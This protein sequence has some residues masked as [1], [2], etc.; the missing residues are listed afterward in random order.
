M[1]Y[2][3]SQSVYPFGF[4]V[5][6]ARISLQQRFTASIPLFIYQDPHFYAVRR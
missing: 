5:A 6:T 1:D 3:L 4:H 2:L